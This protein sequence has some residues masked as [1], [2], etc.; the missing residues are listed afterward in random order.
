MT[1]ET[2]TYIKT[3]NPDNPKG[4]DKIAEGDNHVRGIKTALTGSFPEVDGPVSATDVELSYVSGVTS[5]IQ[6][7]LD[8]Q[9]ATD[10]NLG[11]RVETLEDQVADHETRITT[12]ESHDLADHPSVEFEGTLEDGDV[13]T[14]DGTAWRAKRPQA[15]NVMRMNVVQPQTCGEFTTHEFFRWDAYYQRP[16]NG[17]SSTRTFTFTNPQQGNLK[18]MLRN[19]KMNTRY[20]AN[21]D[22]ANLAIDGVKPFDGWGGKATVSLLEQPNTAE[23][24]YDWEA[25][26]FPIPRRFKNGLYESET[27]DDN[28]PLIEVKSNIVISVSGISA[29]DQWND[30][31]VRVVIEG[32]FVED[33]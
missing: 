16:S 24:G 26:V 15:G 5:P 30:G 13:L 31:D 6:D 32:W 29:N 11:P 14:Y 20:G 7:Q 17:G 28:A 18:F 3:L 2:F 21:L 9:A 10:Q 12:L 25:T 23:G 1:V 27:Y 33:K 4:S 8:A 22:G 19:I